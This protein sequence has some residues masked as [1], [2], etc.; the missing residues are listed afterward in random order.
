MCFCDGKSG[1]GVLYSEPGGKGLTNNRMQLVSG[2]VEA[3]S[4]QS[5][6]A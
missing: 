6:Q 1:R 4:V 2:E 3:V 5:L